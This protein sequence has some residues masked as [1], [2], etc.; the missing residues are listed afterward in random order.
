MVRVME[1]SNRLWGMHDLAYMVGN[2]RA[3]QALQPGRLR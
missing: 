2:K 1:T 3:Y